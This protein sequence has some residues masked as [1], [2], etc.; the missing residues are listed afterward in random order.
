MAAW[1]N[2]HQRDIEAAGQPGLIWMGNQVQLGSPADPAALGGPHR[3]QT[4]AVPTPLAAG[5]DLDKQQQR[6]ATGDQIDL[7]PPA[8]PAPRQNKPAGG[9]EPARDE[10]FCL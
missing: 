3:L 5:F 2:R 8:A 9:G 1:G 4:G 10:G 7:A 6:A